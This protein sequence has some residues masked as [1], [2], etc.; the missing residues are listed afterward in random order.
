MKIPEILKKQWNW[1]VSI[2]LL[3]LLIPIFTE[4]IS[5]AVVIL[6]VILSWN[7]LGLLLKDFVKSCEDQIEGFIQ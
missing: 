2:L 4:N 6:F 7:I 3:L 1:V 5:K